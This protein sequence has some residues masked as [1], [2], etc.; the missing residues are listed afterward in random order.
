[1]NKILA[2]LSLF[3]WTNYLFCQ[4]DTFPTLQ[5]GNDTTLCDGTS[6]TYNLPAGYDTYEWST[7]TIGTS[8]TVNSPTTIWLQVGNVS[9]NL[10]VNGDFEAG[11]TGF[12]S[13]YIYGT[14]GTYGLLSSEG[15][16]A[17]A[18]SPNATHMNFSDCVDH[19]PTGVGNMLV[20]NGSG[21]PN[22][23]VWCQS[24]SVDP[25]TNY[26]FWAKEYIVFAN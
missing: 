14:G 3:I 19:T 7:G 23:S 10:V 8:I 25:N 20:A 6:I 2:L 26:L 17:I 4:C 24:I 5:I 21:T 11:N 22:T 16:Y 1:M 12:S 13:A 18:T 9:P 15:Q